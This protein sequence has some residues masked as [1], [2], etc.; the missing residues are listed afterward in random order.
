[1]FSFEAAGELLDIDPGLEAGRVELGRVWSEED[2]DAG[3][4]GDL[5]IAFLVARVGREVLVGAE[6]RRV[7]EEAGDDKVVFGPGR[8]EEREMALVEGAHGGYEANGSVAW[9]RPQVP[10]R[11]G[12][13]HD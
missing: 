13:L 3:F 9:L 7:D 10:D 2:V 6:L 4:L 12:D 5:R 8:T 11:P 1:M